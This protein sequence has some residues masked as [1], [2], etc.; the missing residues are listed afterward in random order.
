MISTLNQLAI[1]IGVLLPQALGTK[2]DYVWLSVAA[3]AI[4]VVLVPL[5]TTLR[6]S[7]RWLIS[8]GRNMQARRVL[9]WLRGPDY[10][11]E[12]EQNEIETQ[13]LGK[14]K[15]TA[16]NFFKEVTT[17]PVFHPMI[18]S[19]VV[20]F[21]QQFSGIKAVI[22]NGQ[23]IFEEAGVSNAATVTA[24]TIGGVMVIASIPGAILSDI[25]GRKMLLVSGNIVMCLSMAALSVYD[26]L[27]NEP[28]CHPP[29]DPKCKDHLQPLA[30]TAM[31]IY[32]IG[33]S[34][35]WGALPW[36][37]ASEL[38]PLRVRGIGVGVVSCL[39]WMFSMLVLLS[40][41]SYQ[42]AVKPWGVFL[43]FGIINLLSIIFVTVFIPET[44]G[45]SLEEIEQYFSFHRKQYI[46]L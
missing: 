19:T 30:I 20:M 25:I 13:L 33:F 26:L 7:P 12:L 17:R 18:L 36:L 8:H 14:Q 32:M 39:N 29:D 24:I 37:I 42:D 10:N 4:L 28:F 35:A 46:P 22:Y 9:V 38:I 31:I 6:E 1:S 34:L 16:F 44:K 3:L 45:K 21:I 43:S 23:S 2:L 41:G 40:F 11:V 15:M 27:K 5:S